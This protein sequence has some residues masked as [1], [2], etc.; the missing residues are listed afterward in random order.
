MTLCFQIYSMVA[1]QVLEKGS[2]EHIFF[3]PLDQLPC[4]LG[5]A[6]DESFIYVAD[7][8]RNKV[9]VFDKVMAGAAL[10][11]SLDFRSDDCI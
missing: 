11:V 7:T 6:V 2:G 9:V 5:L 8:S 10:Q 3:I 1:A 4:P